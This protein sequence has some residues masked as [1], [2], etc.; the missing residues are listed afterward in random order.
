MRHRGLMRV[1]AVGVLTVT[2]L[3]L[4]TGTAF[5]SS[6]DAGG[7][8]TEELTH[9]DISMN[10]LWIVIGAALVI[11]MQAGFALV[12]TGFTRAKNASHTM[13]MNL[14]I[15]A[16]GV[17]VISRLDTGVELSHFLFGRVL[18]VSWGDVWLGLGLGGTAVAVVALTLSALVKFLTGP[19]AKPVIEKAGLEPV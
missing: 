15:F 6:T 5:A 2:A 14:V 11:F 9:G 3:L 1:A 10:L 16:L 7:T 12:E 8:A 13:M 17:V 4:T 18:T 19:N